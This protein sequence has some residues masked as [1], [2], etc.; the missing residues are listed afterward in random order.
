M[1]SEKVSRKTSSLSLR[2]TL[3]FTAVFSICL[4]L[5]FVAFYFVASEYLFRSA[6]R[7]VAY[8]LEETVHKYKEEGLEPLAAHIIEEA[9]DYGVDKV[10]F[11]LVTGKG[12][13]LHTSDL[14]SWGDVH[15]HEERFPELDGANY[16][17]QTEETPH[18]NRTLR[19]VSKL[20]NSN[21]IVQGGVYVDEELA[22]LKLYRIGLPLLGL[23]VI[24]LAGVTGFFM[25]S[26]AVAR[27]ESVTSLAKRISAGNLAARV[28]VETKMDEIGEL[29]VTFNDMLDRIHN[30]V[31]SL[32]QVTDDV[33]H[34]LRSPI[35]RIRTKAELA[36]SQSEIN[37]NLTSVA[38]NTIDE[39]DR[40]L[41]L[42]NS[43]LD[44]SEADAG[45]ALIDNDQI[46]LSEIVIDAIELFGPVAEA[47]NITLGFQS[48]G[49]ASVEG[50]QSKLQR[51]VS[52]ILDNALKYTP[53]GGSVSV[54]IENVDGKKVQ[55]I[56]EDTGIGIEREALP[57]VFERFYRVEKS[58]STPG[59][60]LG[61][62]LSKALIEA[63][64]GQIFIESKPMKGTT[65]VVELPLA[66]LAAIKNAGHFQLRSV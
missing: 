45:I 11:R 50:D 53:S 21:L 30:L 26:K 66:I 37:Q 56:V 33:A 39:C 10:F 15:V 1:Y 12:E 3:W 22:L 5:I 19:L 13:I 36:L 43:M 18:A 65:V 9:N 7:G 32:K 2:L 17:A 44:I 57:L 54:R 41:E 62:T 28:P 59:S 63:H 23:V 29:S 24:A 8:E 58:R 31:K 61:L 25:V 38:E 6:D 42:I 55:M 47:K 27:V 49:P 64:G 35:T 51:A 48:C 14:S 46:N 20:L 4:L 40:L 34:E 52:N 16:I 60:G